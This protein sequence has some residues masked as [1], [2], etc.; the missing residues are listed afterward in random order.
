MCVYAS[1]GTTYYARI[2]QDNSYLYKTNV[3]V[4]DFS[5]VYF[6]LPKTYF[7]ELVDETQNGFYKVNYLTFTGYVKKDCVQA[8]AGTP[9]TPFLSNIN[10]RVYSEQSRDLRTEPT[11]ISGSSSQVAYIPLMSRN[12]TYFGTIIGEELIDGRTNVWYYCKYSAE[13]DY[14]GY[15]YSDFCDELTPIKENT[16]EVTYITSPNFNPEPEPLT[17]L[18]LKNKTTGIIVAVLCIPAGIFLFMIFKTKKIIT[19]PKVKTGEVID[20]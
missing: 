17:A 7:V 13:K 14:Y 20:Y 2:M 1:T 10:F 4:D 3:D 16:E 18:P 6:I 12:L 11:T 19:N 5:N 8:I 9:F 15:V